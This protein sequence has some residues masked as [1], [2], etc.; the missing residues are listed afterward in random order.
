MT[1]EEK[2]G[3]GGGGGVDRR[4]RESTYTDTYKYIH[5]RS[6]PLSLSL[7]RVEV[8]SFIHKCVRAHTHRKDKE[9]DE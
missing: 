8:E 6:P 4:D 2:K 9:R 1:H 5:T 7:S 3:G